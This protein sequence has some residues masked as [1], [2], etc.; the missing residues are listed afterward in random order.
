MRVPLTASFR[1]TVWSASFFSSAVTLSRA[2]RWS[3]RVFRLF[4][5]CFLRL[6]FVVRPVSSSS[7]RSSSEKSLLFAGCLM[8]P[9]LSLMVDWL[10]S[11]I[12]GS[13]VWNCPETEGPLV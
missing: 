11:E 9:F 1:T 12:L 5:F 8:T 13:S 4:F 7:C 2:I 6:S 3:S 10:S